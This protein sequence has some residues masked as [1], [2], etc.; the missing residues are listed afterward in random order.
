M[1]QFSDNNTAMSELKDEALKRKRQL[2]DSAGLEGRSTM[3]LSRTLSNFIS[4]SSSSSTKGESSSSGSSTASAISSFIS[5]MKSGINPSKD[6]GSNSVSGGN[7]SKDSGSYKMAQKTLSNFISS[8][9][10]SGNGDGGSKG[11]KGDESQPGVASQKTLN[12]FVKSSDTT[13]DKV[14]RVNESIDISKLIANATDNKNAI[15]TNQAKTIIENLKKLDHGESLDVYDALLKNINVNTDKIEGLDLFLA[16]SATL[17]KPDNRKIDVDFEIIRTNFTIDNPAFI[18]KSDLKNSGY[19]IDMDESLANL[20]KVV[21]LQESISFIRKMGDYRKINRPDGKRNNPLSGWSYLKTI[22]RTSKEYKVPNWAYKKDRKS[23]EMRVKQ[24][25]RLSIKEGGGLKGDAPKE[26]DFTKSLNSLLKFA[27]TMDLDEKEGF[28]NVGMLMDELS[29]MRKKASVASINKEHFNSNADNAIMNFDKYGFVTYNVGTLGSPLVLPSIDL[30]NFNISSKPLSTLKGEYNVMNSPA[31][32]KFYHKLYNTSVEALLRKTPDFRQN[33]YH[34]I[35]VYTIPDGIGK[36]QNLNELVT[37]LNGYNEDKTLGLTR[38]GQN[39][40][41]LTQLTEAYEKIIKTYYVRMQG[42]TVPGAS[43]ESYSIPFLNRNVK[44][45]SN[46]FSENHKITIDFIVDEMGLLVRSFN[47]LTGN[48]GYIKDNDAHNKYA[49]NLF[50]VDFSPENKGRL[51]LVIT[52]NDFRVN[53]NFRNED[54]PSKSN[55]MPAT[56]ILQSENDTVENRNGKQVYGDPRSY[57]QFVLEDVKILGMS[58][59]LQ[60]KRDDA[61]KTTVSLDIIFRRITTVDNNLTN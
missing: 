18:E 49:H 34:G 44:K 51:D 48:F 52:Y 7:P 8:G 50:P 13:K 19:Y 21:Q 56:Q 6:S 15:S 55:Y 32:E 1:K 59:K 60:F 46:N 57:R 47:I 43:M 30:G 10:N 20:P 41:L 29:Q 22:D 11:G 12:N 37:S 33:M 24:L 38:V 54:I 42:L 40:Q 4:S 36:I 2:I 28:S 35:F 16:S 17:L 45:P 3:T 27:S 39:A 58:N 31:R 23:I 5:S 26:N 53:P 61:S 25:N 14:K 9:S